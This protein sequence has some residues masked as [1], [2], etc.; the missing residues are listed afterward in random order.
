MPI[1]TK[2]MLYNAPRHK[3]KP[4]HAIIISIIPQEGNLK[5]T[6]IHFSYL[7][8]TSSSMPSGIFMNSPGADSSFLLLS[9]NSNSSIITSVV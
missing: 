1:S 7:N 3:N 9:Q 8:G 6:H 2:L 5:D 4:S